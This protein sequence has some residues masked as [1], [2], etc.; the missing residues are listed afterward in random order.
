MAVVFCLFALL[1]KHVTLPSGKGDG[2]GRE[3]GLFLSSDLFP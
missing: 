2:P 1:L 3:T